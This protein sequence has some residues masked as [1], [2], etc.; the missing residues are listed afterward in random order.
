MDRSKSESEIMSKNAIGIVE[1]SSIAAGFAAGDAML[2]AGQVEMMLA[3]SICSGK[4][5]LMIGGQVADVEAA[6]R[7]GVAA[8]EGAVIDSAVLTNLHPSVFPAI[9]GATGIEK[10]DA[11]GVIE[12]FSVTSLIEAAD[13][14]VKSAAVQ[15]VEIRLA[16]ALGGKAFATLTGDV[17]S[18]QAAVEAGA[19]LVADKGLLVHSAVI[20][21]P[22]PSLLG[23][24]V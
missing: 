14:A 13:V 17:S 2:K 1:L 20:P 8:C 15:L 4:Y 16:M 6:T 5:L 7:A 18:V 21:R 11:L 23:E 22:H 24:I 9:S 19:G 10:L 3:R 12:S